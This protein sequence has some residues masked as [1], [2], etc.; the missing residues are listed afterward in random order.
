MVWE[1]LDV[2]VILSSCIQVHVACC[3]WG[4]VWGVTIKSVTGSAVSVMF[5]ECEHLTSVIGLHQPFLLA[6]RPSRFTIFDLFKMEM[7]RECHSRLLA[8]C[9]VLLI[10]R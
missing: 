3:V 5:P 7:Y 10:Y 1:I 4:V 6:F 8:T 9:V 2:W